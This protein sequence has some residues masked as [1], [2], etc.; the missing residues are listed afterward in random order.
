MKTQHSHFTLIELLVVI[1]II[2]ILASLLLPS[3]SRA[4]DAAKQISCMNN[5]KQIG[6]S[7]NSYA[8]DN[9]GQLPYSYILVSSSGQISWDDLLS[10]YD[11][12]NLTDSQITAQ[13]A[14]KT[15]PL[16]QCPSDNI[17]RLAKRTV[18]SYSINR[19][20]NAGSGSSPADGPSSVWGIS[21]GTPWSAK[22]SRIARPSNVIT[23]T[24]YLRN[25]NYLGN[26][27]C[28]YV[29]TPLTI[30]NDAVIP[31]HGRLNYLMLD[32][33]VSLLTF[34]ETMSSTGTMSHPCGMWTRVSNDD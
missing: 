13:I 30:T 5:L 10:S 9:K 14:P 2:A 23:V 32:G 16:Y 27:S 29:N 21:S 4:R 19:G 12:R 24:E 7:I 6:L 34:K 28:V 17:V 18:R 20:L 15:K 22:I 1:A 3:L 8:D 31:H 33:H 11:G 26:A 25:S